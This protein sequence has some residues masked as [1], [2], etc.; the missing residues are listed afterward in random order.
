MRPVVLLG[1]VAASVCARADAPCRAVEI[2]FQPVE[3]LQ[4][5]VWI[6]DPRGHF[7]DTV[8]VTRSTGALGLGNRPGNGLFK[9]D[10]RFPYGR[11]EM[12]LPIWAH[13][14]GSRYGR[15]VM[16]GAAGNS[17]D[18]CG[19]NGIAASECDDE[20]IGYHFDVS[21]DEPFF[22]S[23]RGGITQHVNGTD[24]VS[25]ASTFYG[26]K[27][28]YADAPAFSI[29]PPRADLTHFVDAHDSADA[30]G[31]ST[32]N[33][34]VA[35]SGATPAGH[36]KLDPPL[37]WQPPSQGDGQYVLWLEQSRESDFNEYHHPNQP[38]EH[39]ELNGYGHD[40]LGQPSIVYAVPFTVGGDVDLELVRDSY[41]YGDWDGATG[42]V[43][44]ADF[45]IAT[46]DGTGAGRLLTTS[47]DDGVWRIKV[48]A[49]P[50]CTGGSF[51]CEPPA[52][53][54][55]LELRPS[56]SAVDVQ[57]ASSPYGAPASRFDLRY[58]EAAPISDADFATAI[59]SSSM[60]P[61]PGA[62]G[63]PVET[64]LAGL[65][66]QS[67]YT[68]AVRAVAMCGA[69]SAIVSA[70]VQTGEPSFAT[71]RGCFIA[72]AAFGSP[73]AAELGPLRALR[74]RVLLTN[75]L[76][77]LAVAAYY[78]LSPPVARAIESDEWLRAGARALLAP[79]L[80]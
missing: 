1:V 49:L 78:A 59:P 18:S 58:R 76:G 16:G 22:C 64:L 57:F 79:L 62:Q 65:K 74:D 52:P 5:A 15:V 28:A 42:T 21:S 12:V 40:F 17:K 56:S 23:P 68:V 39:I 24:V 35:V 66:P 8:F 55:G 9:T 20:T 80:R 70:E 19:T 7:V 4:I 73:L 30:K 53:P 75:P 60:P 41:G 38:D 48:R 47:D 26:C 72:T 36:A 6:E 34:L 10:F 37:R 25:C 51:A 3:D 11:R 63:S 44:P 67:R 29:Y 32:V 77:R 43:H 50:S 61:P 54:L 71:L 69:P 45:T 13:R 33:D 14:R 46:V 2:T 31:F 27:G